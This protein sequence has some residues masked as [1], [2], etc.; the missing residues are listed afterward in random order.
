M[1]V[2]KVIGTNPLSIIFLCDNPSC[3][4]QI[5]QRCSAPTLT[6]HRGGTASTSTGRLLMRLALLEPKTSPFNNS[7]QDKLSPNEPQM[8]SGYDPTKAKTYK[9]AQPNS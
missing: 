6:P 9:S 1:I 3:G 5:S 7:P 8:G 2:Q 4:P